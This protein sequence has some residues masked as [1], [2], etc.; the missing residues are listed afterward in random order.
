MKAEESG[1]NIL[2]FIY[3][4]EK[5]SADSLP[6]DLAY[7]QSLA[8]N[9]STRELQLP[10]L[11]DFYK[12]VIAPNHLEEKVSCSILKDNFS[13]RTDPSNFTI[14]SATSVIRPVK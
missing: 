4:S 7:F 9:S 2:S 1:F 10:W 8:S 5:V 11:M 13:S 14:I 12:N 6:T 3:S